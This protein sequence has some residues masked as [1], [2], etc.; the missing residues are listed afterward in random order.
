MSRMWLTKCFVPFFFWP[1]NRA[2]NGAICT[3]PW[4]THRLPSGTMGVV[5]RVM[6]CHAA[7]AAGWHVW[8]SHGAHM[9]ESVRSVVPSAMTWHIAVTAGCRVWMSHATCEWVMVHVWVSPC[10]V[11]R[12]MMCHVAVIA[13]CC[14]W[15]SHV[16]CEWIMSHIN[17]W[18]HIYQWF[19][20]SSLITA[21]LS[22]H[23]HGNESY[24]LTFCSVPCQPHE[25][26]HTHTHVRTLTHSHT[27]MKIYM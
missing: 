6:R 22:P 17:E 21:Q 26:S 25:C 3:A 23:V 9:S 1:Q 14:V 5:P 4:P 12:V 19:V 18:W 27:Q 2:P 24:T 13:G 10:V 7:M 11:S 8:M 15:M 20:L 16:S